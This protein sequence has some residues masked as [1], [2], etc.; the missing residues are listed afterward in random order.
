LKNEGYPLPFCEGCV[1]GKQHYEP[2]PK[3]S[4]SKAFDVLE[5]IH[6]NIWGPVNTTL[7]RGEK[8]FVTFINDL[9]WKELCYFRKH[10]GECFEKFIEFKAFVESQFGKKI[11]NLSNNRG[12]YSSKES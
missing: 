7:I 2:F 9:S 4:A 1:L 10:K 12:G 5:L 11:K 8:Y 3:E 6:S